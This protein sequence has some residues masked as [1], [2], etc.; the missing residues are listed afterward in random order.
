[1]V[2]VWGL[3]PQRLS[4]MEPKS[5]LSTNSSIPAYSILRFVKESFNFALRC[6]ELNLTCLPIPSCPR[7]QLILYFYSGRK[8]EAERIAYIR[9]YKN[10]Q[11]L[12]L[13]QSLAIVH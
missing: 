12:L 1:M 3:E 9:I 7:I 6:S 10:R 5:I 2:R 4:A 11:R 13:P 8:P